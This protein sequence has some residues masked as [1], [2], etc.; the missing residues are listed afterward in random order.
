ML[1]DSAEHKNM[2][3]YRPA[4][5]YHLARLP[6]G[7]NADAEAKGFRVVNGGQ[8]AKFS[9]LRCLRT[10]PIAWVTRLRNAF[11]NFMKAAEGPEVLE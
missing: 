10:E 2:T 11:V 9:L 6:P 4:V 1:G 7:T 3:S 5:F 8:S